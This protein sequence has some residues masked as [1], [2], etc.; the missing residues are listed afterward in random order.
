MFPDV[1]VLVGV[2]YQRAAAF[3]VDI[4]PVFAALVGNLKADGV[5]PA[6]IADREVARGLRTGVE[7]LM[8]PSSGRTI[9]A[10]LFPFHLYNP[11]ATATTERFNSQLL[12]P[13]QNVAR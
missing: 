1:R 7:M 10:S 12:R 13:E 3:D 11:F 2:F 8:E 6:A 5:N 9:D 4:D